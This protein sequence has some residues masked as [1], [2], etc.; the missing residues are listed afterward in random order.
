MCKCNSLA[1]HDPLASSEWDFG[2]NDM[3]PADVTSRSSKVVWWKNDVR[4]SWEQRITD[5]TDPRLA[6]PK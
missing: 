3:S 6:E 5:R 2:M 1:T 4:G